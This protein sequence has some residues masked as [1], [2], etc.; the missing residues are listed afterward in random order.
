MSTRA[1]SDLELTRFGLRLARLRMARNLSQ[2]ML[3]ARIASNQR[4][5]AYWED[6]ERVPGADWLDRLAKALGV[7]MDDLWRGGS[8]L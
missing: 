1:A 6:G 3:A 7:S 4:T 2:T 8:G 5:V